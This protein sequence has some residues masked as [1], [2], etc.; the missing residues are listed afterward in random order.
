MPINQDFQLLRPSV[1]GR[2]V[3][4]DTRLA[5]LKEI[6][7]EQEVQLQDPGSAAEVN[8]E[9]EGLLRYLLIEQSTID[10]R[11]WTTAHSTLHEAVSYNLN[12]EYPEDWAIL[13]VFDLD[14]GEQVDGELAVAQ[15]KFDLAREGLLG[16][17]LNVVRR[18]V[19]A[20]FPEAVNFTT[21]GDWESIDDDDT[22]VR[23]R[24]ES[25]NRQNGS[26]YQVDEHSDAWRQLETELDGAE[27]LLLLGDIG[28]PDFLGEQEH[29]VYPY[30][31]PSNDNHRT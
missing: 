12:G 3:N 14:S 26:T 24:I 6:Y 4:S 2:A 8:F 29:D 30:G 27:V 22:A 21:T 25:V 28:G 1:G 31:V 15:A 10:G 13:G 20:H 19:L 17:A 11:H 23:F 5:H 9:N 7:E 16:A 18:T